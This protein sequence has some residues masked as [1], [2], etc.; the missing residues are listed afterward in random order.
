MTASSV[1]LSGPL[2]LV[3]GTG[4]QHR[5]GA[6]KNPDADFA[7]LLSQLSVKIEAADAGKSAQPQPFVAGKA[8]DTMLAG[9]PDTLA[10]VPDTHTASVAVQAHDPRDSLQ[11]TGGQIIETMTGD[12]SV[13]VGDANVSQDELAL[14]MRSEVEI[15]VASLG[16]LPARDAAASTTAG[17]N[18]QPAEMQTLLSSLMQS[19]PL[20]AV[21]ALPRASAKAVS[22]VASAAAVLLP[23]ARTRTGSEGMGIATQAVAREEQTPDAQSSLD[24]AWLEPVAAGVDPQGDLTAPRAKEQ[25][26]PSALVSDTKISVL[27]TQTHHAPVI[28]GGPMAQIADGLRVELAASGDTALTWSPSVSA[29]AKPASD[30]PVKVLHIQLQPADLGTVTVRMSLKEDALELHIEASQQETAQR[31]QQD[32]DSLSKVLRSAGYIIDSAA[33]RVVEPDRSSVVPGQGSAS[34]S[35]SSYQGT[36]GGAPS[37]GGASQGRAHDERAAR[38]H[39]RESTTGSAGSQQRPSSSGRYV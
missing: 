18:A 24:M 14:A 19:T 3:V 5:D 39:A 36:A 37:Q 28:F 32:Q 34:P 16:D 4:P 23:G 1:N 6:G 15:D 7:G 8:I 21:T 13:A 17:A 9:V 11:G 29:T 20:Q 2:N 25:G 22:A 33:I 30:A 10:A 31:L 35:Q 27:Q 38:G 12:A 26:L